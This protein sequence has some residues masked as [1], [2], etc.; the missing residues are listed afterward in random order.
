MALSKLRLAPDSSSYSVT[1]GKEVVSVALDGGAGRYRHDILGASSV[2]SVQWICDR[3]EY[4]YLRTFYS[5]IVDKGSLP[6]AIDLILDDP[7]PVEHKAYFIPGSMTL[8]GQRGLS[9]YVTAQL[10]VEPVGVSDD[11]LVFAALYS[12]FGDDYET[13]FVEFEDV[14]DELTN[15]TIPAD[16]L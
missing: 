6:F 11:D 13:K 5:E 12:E 7:L 14:L 8:T 10:E 2:V 16:M 4:R 15:I 9:Y 3:N 1:D